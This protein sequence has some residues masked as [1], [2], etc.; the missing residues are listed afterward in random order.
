[1]QLRKGVATDGPMAP[2][3]DM[4]KQRPAQYMF[5]RH[6]QEKLTEIREAKARKKDAPQPMEAAE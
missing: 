6:V 4:S 1:L 2:E 5:S 3:V